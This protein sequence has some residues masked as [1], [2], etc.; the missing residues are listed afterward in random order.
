MLPTLL[1]LLFPP[2]KDEQLLSKAR[3]LTPNPASTKTPNGFPVLTCAR[4][5]DP[6]VQ[7]AIK[8][9]KK[10]GSKHSAILLAQLLHDTLLEEL[11]DIEIWNPSEIV[12]VPMPLSKKRRHE[13]GFNQVAK[14]CNE[15]PE[16]LR[17]C[18]VTDVLMQTKAVPMQKT[19]SRK[20]RL[21]NVAGI[22]SVTHPEKVRGAHVV[23]IDDV[24]T[25]GATLDEAL[26]TLQQ[27]GVV[28]SAVALARA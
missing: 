23:L 27:E 6:I 14:V 11:A 24:M 10:H 7:A 12:L 26:C 21:K 3:Y 20:E 15:L 8:T 28:V 17:S 19:L 9:L 13:R 1:S 2:S 4:Y 5:E 16:E 25:T 18:V 22:F